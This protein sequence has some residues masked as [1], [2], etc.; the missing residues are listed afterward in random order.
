MH[1]LKALPHLKQSPMLASLKY[2]DY[3]S[4]KNFHPPKPY[5]LAPCTQSTK[6]SLTTY[7]HPNQ[8]PT[9]HPKY[10][11]LPHPVPTKS[12]NYQCTRTCASDRRITLVLLGSNILPCTDHLGLKN[13]HLTSQHLF[14]HQP[15]HLL[16]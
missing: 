11:P 12:N 3:K 15:I 8:P 13:Y 1:N 4:F 7:N 16:H 14:L 5:H 2:P 9:T 10:C 6:R